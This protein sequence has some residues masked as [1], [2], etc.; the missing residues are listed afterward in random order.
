MPPHKPGA[1]AP[2]EDRLEM[3]RLAIHG[4]RRLRIC[5]LELLRSGR[6]YTVDTLEELA[7]ERPHDQL[8]LV[9]G[10]DAARIAARLPRR[11]LPSTVRPIG[12]RREPPMDA[13]GA[14]KPC[15][16]SR[17]SRSAPMSVPR[18]PPM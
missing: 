7:R 2:A 14:P 4:H 8:F 11:L 12:L 9:L 10:W 15:N 6:S 3:S 16:L 17:L 1:A 13:I 5:D 18:L